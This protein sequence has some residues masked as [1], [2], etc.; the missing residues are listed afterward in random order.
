MSKNI[1]NNSIK[2]NKILYQLHSLKFASAC[3]HIDQVQEESERMK[4]LQKSIYCLR[5]E[6]AQHSTNSALNLFRILGFK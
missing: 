4:E 6:H 1:T 3:Q 2:I 5:Q